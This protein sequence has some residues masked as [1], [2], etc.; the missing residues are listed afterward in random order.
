MKQVL[1]GIALAAGLVGS[2]AQAADLMTVSRFEATRIQPGRA[3]ARLADQGLGYSVL[4]DAPSGPQ[5]FY[6]VHVTCAID[7]SFM[8]TYC[9][10]PVY[11]SYC[12]RAR[13]YCADGG[14]SVQALRLKY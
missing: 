5:G 10:T 1:I 3:I 9:P 14:A 4:H 11:A 12:P 8:Q 6:R 13:I 7:E 2:A